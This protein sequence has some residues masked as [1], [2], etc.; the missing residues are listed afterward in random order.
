MLQET[1]F[2]RAAARLQAPVAHVKAVAQVEAPGGGFDDKGQPRILFEAH[3]FAKLTGGVYNASHPDISSAKWDRSLYARGPNA[4][5][6][7]VGEHARLARAVTLNRSAALMATSWGKFQI[8]GENF[9]TCGYPTLQDFINAM[10]ANEGEQLDAFI[11][12]ILGDRRKHPTSGLT[13]HGALRIGDWASFASLY[14]GPAYAQN[15]YDT[16]LAAAAKAAA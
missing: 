11:G 5:S 4:D 6:R 14:N 9:A 1:D 8:L 10:Y 16:K 7:N 12:Y 2:E 3:R 15:Q 13:M